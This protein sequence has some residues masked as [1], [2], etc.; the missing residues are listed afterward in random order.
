MGLTNFGGGGYNTSMNKKANA[1]T[2][3]ELL[4]VIVVIAILAAVSVV[5]YMGIQVRARDTQRKQDVATIQRALELYYIDNGRYPVSSCSSG[6]KINGSW[7]T[8]SDGS[9][10][11]LAAQLVPKYISELPSDPRASTTTNPAISNGFN[12]DYAAPAAWCGVSPGQIYLLSF[13]LESLSHSYVIDGDCPTSQP[14]NY[15]SSEYI[16][17][18]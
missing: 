2:I 7:S 3:V 12:Y 5:A 15:G 4:I 6:C 11:N 14:T 16:K 8:T 9:W 13:R 10:A 18:K 17:V 1:Y